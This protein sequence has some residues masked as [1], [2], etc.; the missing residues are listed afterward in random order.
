[1][2]VSLIPY[3]RLSLSIILISLLLLPQFAAA[4]PKGQPKP[5]IEFQDPQMEAD[6]LELAEE[7]RCLVCQ[8]QNL[9]DS[10]ADLADDLRR[11]VAKLLKG[12]SNKEQVTEFMVS[13]Y[14]DFVLYNPPVKPTTWLLWGGP[15]VLMFI[16][17]FIVIR[18]IR[19]R[20]DIQENNESSEL[21][22]LEKERLG[23]ILNSPD[24]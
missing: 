14:G 4:G 17:V 23:K 9:I 22:E 3:F 13:R 16:A 11:E 2:R 24:S 21:T 6:Y 19:V 5:P 7:L 8:N 15:F 20:T 18:K 1:M 12:G 10:N